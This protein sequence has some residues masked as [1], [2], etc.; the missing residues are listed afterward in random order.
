MGSDEPLV[1]EKFKFKSISISDIKLCLRDIKSNLDE[2]KLNVRVLEDCLE[3]V[4]TALADVIN[5]SLSS[6]I[7]LSALKISTIIP[8]Q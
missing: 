3:L 2:Y 1:T 5:E 4:A 8:I 6:V 7:F